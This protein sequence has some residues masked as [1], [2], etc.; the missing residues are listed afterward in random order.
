MPQTISD[1][2]LAF[3]QR[4]EGF[5]E[6][7]YQDVVGIW[8]IGYGETEIDGRPVRK[9]DVLP[10]A[11]ALERLRARCNGK[12][13]TGVRVALGA[14]A[15]AALTQAQF[16]A[17]VSLAYNIGTAGFRG[18]TVAHKLIAGDTS[19]ASAAFLMWDKGGTPRRVLPVLAA[20]RR[21]ERR[22]FDTGLYQ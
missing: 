15:T 17:L 21:R 20:R 1:A 9:G 7:A 4:E 13:G 8:T 18:S 6:H 5:R 2:G 14:V 10:L 11:A 19:A 22:L 3:I 12:F 16:D